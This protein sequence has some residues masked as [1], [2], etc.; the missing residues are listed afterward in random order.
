MRVGGLLAHPGD[1]RGRGAKFILR[2]PHFLYEIMQ[3]TNQG[4][5]DFAQTWIGSPSHRRQHLLRELAFVGNNHERRPYG[6]AGRAG[7]ARRLHRGEPPL[8]RRC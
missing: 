6:N 1:E 4:D 8:A 3:V 2:Q 5:Q 7:L